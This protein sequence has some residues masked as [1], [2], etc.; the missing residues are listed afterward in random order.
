MMNKGVLNVRITLQHIKQH[1]TTTHKG[2]YIRNILPFI[3]VKWELC[4]QLFE[5]LTLSANPLDKWFCPR[6]S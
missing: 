2:F 6:S 4:V 5:K 3:K 1:R